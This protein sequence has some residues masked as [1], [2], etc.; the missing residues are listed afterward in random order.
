MKWQLLI[1]LNDVDISNRILDNITIEAEEDTARVAEFT[2]SS[3]TYGAISLSSLI[4]KSVTIDYISIIPSL[5]PVRIFTGVVD[6]PEYD[7][8][9]KTTHL[10]CTDDMQKKALDY[11]NKTTGDFWNNTSTNIAIYEDTVSG[12][13]D[14]KKGS[15]QLDISRSTLLKT[16]DLN[17]FGTFIATP[18]EP[19]TTPDYTFYESN[20]IYNS[21][22]VAF[23]T[24][25]QIKNQINLKLDYRYN[26][27]KQSNFLYYW[28]HPGV[29]Y[30]LTTGV[31]YPSLEMV[32]QA[33]NSTG[34]KLAGLTTNPPPPPGF[35]VC[36]GTD[37]A[38]IIGPELRQSL[39]GE[40][41]IILSKRYAQQVTD[42]YDIVIK[43]TASVENLG[44]L[45]DNVSLSLE[46]NSFNLNEWLSNYNYAPN[47]NTPEAELIH[48]TKDFNVTIDQVN[49]GLKALIL[50]AKRDIVNSHRSN[51]V[52]FTTPIIPE[53][54]RE[55]TVL[56]NTTDVQAKGKIKHILHTFETQSG[57]AMSQIKVAL[58]R[59]DAV[60]AQPEESPIINPDGSD[61]P[62]GET[63]LSTTLN[64]L[65]S[66][67]ETGNATDTDDGY[68]CNSL[69]GTNPHEFRINVPEITA[70]QQE[71]I[72]NILNSIYE[73]NI[74][75]DLLSVSA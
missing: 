38:W 31:G 3:Y 70:A 10:R 17:R 44:S 74:R 1:K 26:R 52:Q 47:L 29:C 55:H 48:D 33:S 56:I 68:I 21:L 63:G 8:K 13:Y 15:E 58:S 5:D 7:I 24:R 61:T 19:K 23:S 16:I 25:Q 20:I 42:K 32:K 54:D 43:S 34:F 6:Y 67:G 41:T 50:K 4:G 22:S 57:K 64:T 49:N 2:I 18:F 11:M 73:V 40:S 69:N 12:A 9:T 51:Y 53:I 62:D 75:D 72:T 46:S 39:V 37:T 30:S 14:K 65:A 28:Q 35:Y 71:A 27:L 60:E 59:I 45:P 66:D 36:G